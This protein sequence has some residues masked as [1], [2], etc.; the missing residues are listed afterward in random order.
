VTPTPPPA[1]PTIC[2]AVAARAALLLG[3]EELPSLRR[4]V[5]PLTGAPLPAALLKHSDEQTVAAVAAV[6]RAIEADS[7]DPRSLAEWGVLAAPRFLGRAAMGG[8]L[9]R[10]REEGAWGVSPHL[11]PHRSLHSV[12]GTVSLALRMHGPNFGAGGGPGAES[13][14]FA[15]V[16]GLLGAGDMHGLW[17]VLTGY[18]PELA[19]EDPA[20]G[21]RPA[22]LPRLAAVAVALAPAELPRW[23]LH[24]GAGTLRGCPA[25]TLAGLRRAVAEGTPGCWALDG[26]GWVELR[27]ARGAT[28]N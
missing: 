2:C 7:L 9:H 10:F 24:L 28:G 15:V 4:A 20:D 18:E 5:S 14:A 27:P 26:G 8:V 1:A 6:F 16:A 19:P 13:E 12:S 21:A 3:A 11:I 23:E 25:L 22:P 17:V